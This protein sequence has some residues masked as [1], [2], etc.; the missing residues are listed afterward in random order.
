[1][2]KRRS[3]L[4]VALL[5]C[6]SHVQ[7]QVADAPSI[8]FNGFGTLGTVYSD[9][10]QATFV[11]SVFVPKGAGYKSEWSAEVDS[12]LGLQL[13][14]NLT[15]RLSSVLQV[16]V[17]QDY[18]GN[19]TP[20][21][22]W[23]NVKFE[24]SSDLSLRA[25]RILLPTFMNSEYRKVGYAIPWIRPPQ[26]VYRT[27]PVSNVDGIDAAYRFRFDDFTN[28]LRATYGQA[29]KT[30]PFADGTGGWSTGD[31]Q[32]REGLTISNTLERGGA[33]IFAAYN[34]FRLTID[35]LNPLFDIYRMFGPEGIA[36]AN[37]YDLD[38]KRFEM[39]T[40][41][42][43]YDAGDWFLMGEWTQMESQSLFADNRSWY[44][45][46]GYRFGT[47]TPYLTYA[48]QRTRNISSNPGLSQPYSEE[49]DAFLQS[50]LKSQ[51]RQESLSLGVRWDFTRSMA[52]KA[53]YDHMNLDSGSSGFLVNTQPE[54]EP[55]GT[56][57][58]FSLALDFVF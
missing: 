37:R 43:S 10:D 35:E 52:L 19:Y 38:D 26:E 9:E 49:L 17:E 27:V 57:N 11:S 58:L 14:A 32:A 44:V 16:I 30:F 18:N 24:V 42:A 5:A 13:T 22:E 8:S 28:T 3:A 23:A 25:G 41:G 1:M 15:P 55:G 6:V 2:D 54:F 7:A 53:Q 48:Q 39:L 34:Q 45:T 46:S 50:I 31:A 33:S 20:D 21:I 47:I 36:L 51:P 40:L 4:A 29:D 56:V 12:R